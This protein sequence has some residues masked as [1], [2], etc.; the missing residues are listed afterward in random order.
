MLKSFRETECQ[1]DGQRDRLTDKR[2]DEK[3]ASQKKVTHVIVFNLLLPV[4]S[5]NCNKLFA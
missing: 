3:T 2:I 1:T 4:V 5:M